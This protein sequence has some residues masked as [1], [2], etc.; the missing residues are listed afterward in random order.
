MLKEGKVT[1]DKR[2]DA[3]LDLISEKLQPRPGATFSLTN[4]RLQA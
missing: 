4:V 3:V 2:I 1:L